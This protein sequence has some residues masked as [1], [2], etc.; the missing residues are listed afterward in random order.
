MVACQCK[1]IR[2]MG[3]PQTQLGTCIRNIEMCFPSMEMS[4][5]RQPIR[6]WLSLRRPEFE[7]AD[8]D[9]ELV[10]AQELND[11]AGH[12]PQ[13]TE[14]RSDADSRR[15]WQLGN[16]NHDLLSDMVL[17]DP[18]MTTKVIANLVFELD[19]VV[20]CHW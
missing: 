6:E 2:N 9:A 14:V 19:L 7:H 5:P 17:I 10:N 8:G 18:S 20:K 4:D 3:M 15:L 13:L 1:R 12:Q 11:T 16:G